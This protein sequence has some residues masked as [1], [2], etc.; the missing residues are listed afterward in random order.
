MNYHCFSKIISIS[1]YLRFLGKISPRYSQPCHFTLFLFVL[2]AFCFFFFLLRR[3][4]TGKVALFSWSISPFYSARWLPYFLEYNNRP[5]IN[6]FPQIIAHP[7]SSPPPLSPSSLSFI[8]SPVMLKWNMIHYKLKL[9]S[10]D[11]SSENWS[12]IQ[13]WNTWKVHVQFIWCTVI[14]SFKGILRQNI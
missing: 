7:P 1:K 11:S 4:A 6:R 5:S 14:F 13:I 10:N 12:R 8:P 2:F 9:I 3:H